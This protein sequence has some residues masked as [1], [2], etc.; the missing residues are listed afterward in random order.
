MF[1]EA[2]A[3]MPM[4]GELMS[5]ATPCLPEAS[6]QQRADALSKLLP[7]PSH[8]EAGRLLYT[9]VRASRPTNVVE[10]GMSLW[11]SPRSTWRRP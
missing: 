11:A 7:A 6:E 1:T 10:F 3:Q 4:L 2:D 8:P 5:Q 9:L